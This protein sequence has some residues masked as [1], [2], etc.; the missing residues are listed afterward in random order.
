MWAKLRLSLPLQLLFA[1]FLAWSIATFLPLPN[2]LTQTSWYQL[3][4]LGKATY[5]GLL[6]MVVGIVVMLSLL[7]GI[8]SIAR[9]SN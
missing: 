6:K 9:R 3:I 7:Q 5:I 8:T 1:A 4:M 2:N